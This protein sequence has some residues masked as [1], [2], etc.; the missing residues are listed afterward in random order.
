MVSLQEQ[1]LKAKLVD[2]KKI[3]RANQDKSRQKKI[4]R[5]TGVQELDESRQAALEAQQKQR[6]TVRELNAQRDAE[7]R[8]KAIQAQIQQMIQ[9]SRQERGSGDIAYNYTYG[10]KI[11]RIYVSAA[12]RDQLAAGQLVIVKPADT[13]ELVPRAVADKIA[14]RD[15]AIVVRVKKTELQPAEDDPYAEYKIPD[16]LMW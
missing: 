2:Q 10:G 7:A 9:Q 14:E 11:E 15:P 4:Q 12:V 8:K 16:D 3:K 6:E 1:L 5:R 13:A